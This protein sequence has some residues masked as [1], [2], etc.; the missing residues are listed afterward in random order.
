MRSVMCAM[1]A[2]RWL[3]SSAGACDTS[4]PAFF[5]PSLAKA[6]YC[7]TKSLLNGL[8]VLS[9]PFK[10][11]VTPQVSFV[12]H[13]KLGNVIRPQGVVCVR[14]FSQQE[15]SLHRRATPSLGWPLPCALGRLLLWIARNFQIVGWKSPV[16]VWMV[17][18]PR[19][20]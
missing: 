3:W 5:C 15:S 2:A 6:M 7:V 17:S 16:G 18:P 1:I 8:P 9:V 14:L 13:G 4:T 19:L 20:S 11:C 12:C 10:S